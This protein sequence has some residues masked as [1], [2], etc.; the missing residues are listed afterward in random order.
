ME[1]AFVE[2]ADFICGLRDSGATEE[3]RADLTR[4]LERLG[5]N[6]W[7]TLPCDDDLY[8]DPEDRAELLEKALETLR[9]PG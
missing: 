8:P 1:P 6:E 9:D 4:L 3:I 7:P 5:R 2:V